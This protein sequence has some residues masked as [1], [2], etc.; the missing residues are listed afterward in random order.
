[1]REENVEEVIAQA[2]KIL[3]DAKYKLVDAKTCLG[4]KPYVCDGSECTGRN[5][6]DL[7]ELKKEW[8][9]KDAVCEDFLKA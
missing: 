1:M 6:E 3:T 7:P 9:N 8:E 5:K 2:V 4:F